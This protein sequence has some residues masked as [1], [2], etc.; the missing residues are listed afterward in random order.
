[1]NIAFRVDSSS[2][3]G[4][5]HLMR[6]LALAKSFNQLNTRVA[7]VTREYATSLVRKLKNTEQIVWSLLADHNK[8]KNITADLNTWLQGTPQDDV[9]EMYDILPFKPDVIITDHYGINADWESLVKQR[10]AKVI[11]IDDLANRTHNCDILIDANLVDNYTIRY[12]KIVPPK[13][14]L[15]LGPQYAFIKDQMVNQKKIRERRYIQNIF[16]FY[17]ASNQTLEVN[18]VLSAL[19]ANSEIKFHVILGTKKIYQSDLTQKY[20]QNSNIL[21]YEFIDD[22]SELLNLSDIAFA[23]G[24]TNTWERCLFGLPTLV[25]TVAE[26]QVKIAQYLDKIG[27]IRYLGTSK[28]V[29]IDDIRSAFK[30]IQE[31][32]E[33]QAEIS[34][35]SAEIMKEAVGIDKLASILLKEIGGVK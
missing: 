16:I 35:K 30:N 17:G 25:T 29:S 21:F 28:S 34:R 4:S 33:Q 13:A 22:L 32:P 8:E 6:C 20:A 12:N 15:L 24:G 27:C 19:S 3:I 18:K 23:A 31:H 11:A 1:M 2:I 7:I 5:G 10:G 9:N 14:K 26:N